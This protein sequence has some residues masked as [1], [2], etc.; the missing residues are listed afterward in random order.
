M[1]PRLIVDLNKLKWNFDVLAKRLKDFGIAVMAVTKG[2]GA[3][4]RV[5]ELAVNHPDIAFLADSRISNLKKYAET[6]RR[7]GKQTVLLR[8]P[9]HTEV[10]DV[11]R[12][13]DISLNSELSTVRMLNAA[14]ES[15]GTR[16]K[17][18]LM[19]DMG[20]LREGMIFTDERAIFELCR[21]VLALPN[22]ELH[23]VGVNLTCYGGVIPSDQNLGTFCKIAERIEAKF[24]IRLNLVSG[25]NSSSIPLALSGK[26]PKK[27]NNLRLGE[28]LLLGKE[29]AYGGAIEGCFCDAVQLEAQIVELKIKP[30]VPIGDIGLVAF[31]EKP[32]FTDKGEIARAIVAIGR[33]DTNID[34]LVPADCGITVLGASSDHT[35]LDITGSEN[36]YSV[37]DTVRFGLTYGAMLGA[38]VSSYVDKV[39]I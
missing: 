18:V 5:V 15:Q 30:S 38:A 34:G 27:V 6:A 28:A 20:D 1:Y 24:G 16:H 36:D 13:A 7:S 11:V 21:N 26:M 3:D 32:A 22:I 31:G 35:I 29:T 10:S 8:L 12:Y 23:G 4:Q 39:Y 25:G 14:A 37:G 2:I 17:V 33:Q 19:L 9:M